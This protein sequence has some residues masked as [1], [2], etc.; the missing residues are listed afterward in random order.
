M[1]FQVAGVLESR[2]AGPTFQVLVLHSTG[3]HMSFQTVCPVGL[4]LLTGCARFDVF[5]LMGEHV[6]TK[7]SLLCVPLATNFTPELPIS[8]F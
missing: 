4:I 1:S 7:T 5:L 3:L 8:A 6:S 2:F